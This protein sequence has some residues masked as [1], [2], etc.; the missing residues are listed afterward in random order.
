[1]TGDDVAITF[2][3]MNVQTAS[4]NVYSFATRKD[5]I[6]KS[7]V[8]CVGTQTTGVVNQAAAEFATPETCKENGNEDADTPTKRRKLTPSDENVCRK[9]GISFSSKMDDDYDS[10]WVNC[11]RRGCTYWVHMYCLG[12]EVDDCDNN[13][14]ERTVR[15]YCSKHNPHPL[16]RAKSSLAKKRL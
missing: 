11:S 9:C 3:Q 16:P 4:K 13:V 7:E 6:K 5:M 10:T 14:F 2:E 12:L 1:M 15:Y 8:A